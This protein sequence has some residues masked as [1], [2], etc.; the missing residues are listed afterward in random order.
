MAATVRMEDV[1]LKLVMARAF[2]AAWLKYYRPGR[3]TMASE[4][5]RTAL[6]KHL[7]EMA[8]NGTTDEAQLSA[9]GLLHLITL[10]P[11][12]TYLGS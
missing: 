5:A 1:E 2:D 7:V 6:A 11:S 12:E 8:K 9:S 3:V 10:T 4:V